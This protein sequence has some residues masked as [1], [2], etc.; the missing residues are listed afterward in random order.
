M[1]LEKCLAC[2]SESLVGGELDSPRYTPQFKAKESS[3]Y[4]PPFGDFAV[5]G[6]LC[7]DCGFIHYFADDSFKKFRE[8]DKEGDQKAAKELAQKFTQEAKD[9]HNKEELRGCLIFGVMMLLFCLMLMLSFT[10]R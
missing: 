9:E 1:A 10:C 8:I 5:K 6:R 4:D 3:H 7:L 2:G